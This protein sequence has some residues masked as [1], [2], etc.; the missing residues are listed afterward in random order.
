MYPLTIERAQVHTYVHKCW[1]LKV[2]Y[3][4]LHKGGFM[5]FPVRPRLA[6]FKLRPSF[7][8]SAAWLLHCMLGPRSLGSNYVCRFKLEVVRIALQWEAFCN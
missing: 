3:V 4:D 2:Y 6:A 1:L 5:R 8:L 7:L